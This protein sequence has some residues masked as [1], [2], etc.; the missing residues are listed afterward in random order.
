MAC[1]QPVYSIC[2]IIIL[3]KLIYT[4]SHNLNYN[5][6]ENLSMS[7]YWPQYKVFWKEK[8]DKKNLKHYVCALP[9]FTQ[10]TAVLSSWKMVQCHFPH[11]VEPARKAAPHT[12]FTLIK[13]L[14]KTHYMGFWFFGA[15]QS[16][17]GLWSM[18]IKMLPGLFFLLTHS[19]ILLRN[20]R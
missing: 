18:Y 11:N 7:L 8:T 6:S 3:P 15:A 12:Y 20:H 16:C 17:T 13:W 5:F 1:M 10:R 9:F 4:T 19:R 2:P 14:Y